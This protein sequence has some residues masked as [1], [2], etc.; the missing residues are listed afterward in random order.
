M[1]SVSRFALSSRRAAA[2]HAWRIVADGGEPGA[3]EPAALAGG[4]VAEVDELYFNTPARRKFLKSEATEFGRCEEVFSRMAL[5]RPDVAF[6]LTHN[7]RR[8]A[9]WAPDTLVR[10]AEAVLGEDFAR[11]AVAVSA[12]SGQVRIVGLAAA[13]GYTRAARDAQYFYVNGRFVRDKVAAHAIREAY[14]D[15]L[16]HDRHAAFVLFLDID[17]RLVD[18]NVHPAKTEVRFRESG[19]VHQF[20]LHAVARALAAPISGA[21][22]SAAVPGVAGAIGVPGTAGVPPASPVAAGSDASATSRGFWPQ[23]AFRGE[24]ASLAVP[25]PVARYVLV[26]VELRPVQDRVHPNL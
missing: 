10:R 26:A 12:A 22:A 14:A 18:V 19:A 2:R 5:S 3:P 9:H 8:V 21:G 24:Q 13:P 20:I 7:G 11:H 6:S 4:T 15:V 16:H 1:A 17:P 25:Q 23:A